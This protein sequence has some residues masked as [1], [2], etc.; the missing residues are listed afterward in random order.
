LEHQTSGDG[1]DHSNRS[2]MK[3]NQAAFDVGTLAI[4]MAD[5]YSTHSA[6]LTVVTRLDAQALHRLAWHP[7]PVGTAPTKDGSPI[8]FNLYGFLSLAMRRSVIAAELPR[9]WLAGSLLAVGDAL[10][11]NSYFDRAPQLELVRHLRNG[12]AH[13]NRFDI[14]DLDKLK[15][16]PAH[17]RDV[18]PRR[19]GRGIF[20]IIPELDETRVLFDFME[21]GDVIEAL[22]DVG[23]Y[24]KRLGN[25]EPP[26]RRPSK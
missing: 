15:E 4:D 9:V 12:I 2:A 14:R 25:G 11:R 3:A 20:E 7:D 10:A 16:F 8:C 26:P 22:H 23:V 24:L 17:N 1:E 18:W 5:G 19:P 21:A 6:A 13:G